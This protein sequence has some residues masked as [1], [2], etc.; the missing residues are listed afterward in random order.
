MMEIIL[1]RLDG[2]F[3]PYF[4]YKWKIPIQPAKGGELFCGLPWWTIE[5]MNLGWNHQPY[6]IRAGFPLSFIFQVDN[7]KKNEAILRDFLQKWSVECRADGLI[8]LRFAIFPL[9]LSKV[10][11]LPR[12]SDA[13]SYEVLHLSRKII[14]A[15]LKV[16]C[17]KMQPFSGNLRPHLLTHLAHVSLVLRLPRECIFADPLQMSHACHL[18]RTCY[19]TLTFCSLLTR[20]TIPCACHGKRHLNVQKCSEPFSFL[21]FLLANVL[22]TTTAC[23]FSFLIWPHGSA[24]A[25]LVSLLFDPPEPHIIGKTQCFA[26]FLS[27]R[28]PASSFFWLFLF[29]SFF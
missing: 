18:F 12:K 9:H 5:T 24:P 22:R 17:S 20:C 10:L 6:G 7:R 8:P 14:L 27:F 28:A 29:S 3:N 11:R 21:I 26:T 1:F 25:A 2:Y 13:R 19:K 15:N 4:C 16:S 23:I